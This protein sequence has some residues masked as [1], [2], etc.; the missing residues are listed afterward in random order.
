M[1]AP[2]E[3]RT[4]HCLGV[5]SGWPSADRRHS[6]YIYQL[7]G[8]Q[9]MIDCGE[10]ASGAHQG[11]GFLPDDIDRIVFSHQHSDHVGGFSMLMQ[12]MWVQRRRKPLVVHAPARAIPALQAWLEATLLF[13]QLLGFPIQWEPLVPGEEVAIG[14][15]RL[16]AYA[17][18]H[19]AWLEQSFRAKYP[20]PSFEA[21]S[22][23]LEG[24]GR[25][26]AHSADIGAV[27]DLEPL[28]RHPLDLLVC[29]VAHVDAGELFGR[30]QSAVIHE[31]VL[32]HL[33]HLWWD[34]RE[35]LCRLA[36]E[37]LPGVRVRVAM[38]RD[39]I[40]IN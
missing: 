3:S 34:D 39:R 27:A 37:R 16:T 6:S 9:L 26:V 22:F 31:L 29:E 36:E 21:F 4:L 2:P 35:N 8:A 40:Q 28:L 23:L 30:L 11:M 13:D 7:G 32:I 33:E 15:L 20:E 10:G 25:R 5:A 38:D 12:G 19:L 17:S 1:A 14:N 24:E 18:S